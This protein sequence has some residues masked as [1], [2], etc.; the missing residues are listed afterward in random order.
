MPVSHISMSAIFNWK[1]KMRLGVKTTK[2]GTWILFLMT[3][4]VG[5]ALPPTAFSQFDADPPGIIVGATEGGL[6]YMTGGVG[7][8]EREVME[9][10]DA[11]FNL[12]L[13][14]AGRSGNFLSEVKLSIIDGPGHNVE[15]A[16]S[17][18]PWFYI[19]LPPGIYTVVATF[20]NDTK[21]IKNL[22]LS[23][24]ERVTRFLHWPAAEEE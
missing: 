10:L 23:R 11:P 12:K 19:K 13:V 2:P 8:D 16:I 4:S 9:S 20:N 1:W 18:G 7:A 17:N 14:F 5:V 6:R 3:S 15:E 21:K 22:D 24:N